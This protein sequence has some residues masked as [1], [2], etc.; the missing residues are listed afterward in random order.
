MRYNFDRG[1]NLAAAETSNAYKIMIGLVS[2]DVKSR[3]T[4]TRQMMKYIL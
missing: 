1:R 2:G 4:V 3:K